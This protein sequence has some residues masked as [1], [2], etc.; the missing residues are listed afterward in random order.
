MGTN[1]IGIYFILFHTEVWVTAAF[2]FSSFNLVF[3]G[4][5]HFYRGFG[6]NVSRSAQFGDNAL[7]IAVLIACSALVRTGTAPAIFNNF[8]SQIAIGM[9][10]FA[11]GG[12]MELYAFAKTR[13]RGTFLDTIHNLLVVPGFLFI[14]VTMMPVIYLGGSFWQKVIAFLCLVIWFF[15]FLWDIA[16]ERL[17]QHAWLRINGFIISFHK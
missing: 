2:L 15:L 14:L 4:G 7:I 5:Q 6:Y 16:A 8:W 17:D 9:V 1:L 12:A 11:I 10:S 3:F 13:R